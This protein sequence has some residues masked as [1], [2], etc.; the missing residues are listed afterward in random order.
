M[1]CNGLCP[2]WLCTR[3][4]LGT[5]HRGTRLIAIDDSRTSSVTGD[6]IGRKADTFTFRDGGKPTRRM[7]RNVRQ[8]DIACLS[9]PPGIPVLP[10]TCSEGGVGGHAHSRNGH[11]TDTEKLIEEHLNVK[12]Y[13]RTSY[14]PCIPANY[15]WSVSPF[16]KLPTNDRSNLTYLIPRLILLVTAIAEHCHSQKV[17]FT[18]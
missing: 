6:A 9:L 5:V 17:I 14:D 11:V 3:P 15:P 1:R 2:V 16:I 13:I 10:E 8:L 7:P 12:T 18:Q 4:V